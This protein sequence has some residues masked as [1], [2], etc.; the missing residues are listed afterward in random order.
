M[1][2]YSDPATGQDYEEWKAGFAESA[3]VLALD[4]KDPGDRPDG[5]LGA[6]DGSEGKAES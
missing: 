1:I 4:G 6:V 3:P 5:R 2:C